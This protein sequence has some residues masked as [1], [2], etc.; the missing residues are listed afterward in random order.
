MNV[1]SVV[2]ETIDEYNL[3]SE[4][5]KIA[6]AVSGG[7]DS[8]SILHILSS[9]YNNITALFVDVG[10]ETF[11]D[12]SFEIVSSF[13]S[14]QGIPLKLVRL[15]DV[16]GFTTPEAVSVIGGKPCT[17]CSVLKRYVLNKSARG[18]DKLVTGHN[19]DD[20]AESILMNIFK[21]NMSSLA[22][23]GPSSGIM[24]DNKFVSRVK[25]LYFVPEKEV[26]H[27]AVNHKLSFVSH[28]CPLRGDSP[29]RYYVKQ[30]LNVL[31][32]DF[33]NVKQNIVNAF[34]KFIKGKSLN[35]KK[36]SYCKYCG[37]PSSSD[38]CNFCK[39]RL[40]VERSLKNV[41]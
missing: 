5:D 28:P 34:L 30:R 25:P 26:L 22:S 11:S 40:Q 2:F 16:L 33:P 10:I 4:A 38:I 20:A 3:L 24:H 27:Y 41:R 8:M 17:T 36:L 18:F 13:C 15:K 31:E 7:K 35:L 1:E 23:L 19:L 14:S 29:F 32:K 21:A 39:I 6:V 37:E 12:E 9:K